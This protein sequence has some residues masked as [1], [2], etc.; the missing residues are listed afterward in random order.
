MNILW[1]TNVTLADI[2]EKENIRKPNLGG[3][4]Q[5]LYNSLMYYYK[6]EINITLVFP[7]ETRL[8]GLVNNTAYYSFVETADVDEMEEFF[9]SIICD[10]KLDIIHIFG[11]EYLHSYS[12]IKACEKGKLIDNTVVSIQGMVSVYANHMYNNLPLRTVLSKNLFDI[13]YHT[14]IRYI[15]KDFFKRG[16]YEKKTIAIAK[17]ITGRTDWDKQCT[18]LMNRSAKYYHC[19]EVL[20]D[21][22]YQKEQWDISKCKKKSIFFSQCDI[23]LKGVHNAIEA[24]YIIK[25]DYNDVLLF[26]AG[27]TN[28]ISPGNGLS[29]YERYVK[30]L[31]IKYNLQNNIVFLGPQNEEEMLENYLRANVFVCASSIENS[32]NSVCEAMI[33]GTPV[34]ASQVGGMSNLIEHGKSGFLYQADAP[35]MLAYYVKRILEDDI[36]GS[37]ISK[38][39]V[40]IAQSRHN[41]KD[42]VK[43]IMRIYYGIAK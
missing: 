4:I 36:L 30:N 42:I 9:Y 16:E 6:D 33:V 31:I 20:R 24:L 15:T 8:R 7:A 21:S 11:T 1:L 26:V 23:S 40:D 25:Q 37:T 2:T 14:A 35:Y 19:G 41:R 5:G 28:I 38:N 10:T 32:S 12:M 29:S 22:F 13:K 34:V 27:N 17:N 43:E 3:W 39:A 18:Y